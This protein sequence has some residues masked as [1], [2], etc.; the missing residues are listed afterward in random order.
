[1]EKLNKSDLKNYLREA[2]SLANS[3]CMNWLI[4]DHTYNRNHT[5]QKSFRGFSDIYN[6]PFSKTKHHIF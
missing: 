6:S 5:T 4:Y 3:F 1:M 2:M